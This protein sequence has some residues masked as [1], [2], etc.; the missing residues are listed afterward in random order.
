MIRTIFISLVLSGPVALA[1]DKGTT[2]K[3]VVDPDSGPVQPLSIHVGSL[4][5][6]ELEPELKKL[7]DAFYAKIKDGKIEDGW[8]K[9]LDGSR[10][11]KEPS[12]LNE[13]ITKTQEIIKVHGAVQD[14]E[15]LR[16]KST[17]K[18]LREI[19]YQL[20]CKDHPTRWRIFAYKINDRWQILDVDVSSDLTR[21]FE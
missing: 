19:I 16:V 21:M 9:L 12:I 2:A 8:Q 6:T 13:F 15:L 10:I 11:G 7:F 3:R 1:Q 4:S 5:S 14:F 18:H 20:S 17:G